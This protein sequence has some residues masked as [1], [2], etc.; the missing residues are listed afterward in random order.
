MKQSDQSYMNV[1]SFYTITPTEFEIRC[2]HILKGYAEKEG[3]P[4]FTITHDEK[5]SAYD[6]SYQ[7][8]ILASFTA[9]GTTIT[10]LCECKRYKSPVKQ[11]VVLALESKLQSIGAHKGIILSTSKFQRGAIEYAQAHGIALIQMTDRGPEYFSHSSGPF[12]ED[13]NDPFLYGERHLPPYRATLVTPN[14]EDDDNVVF[15]PQSLINSIYAEMNR[16]IEEQ[17]GLSIKDRL[18]IGE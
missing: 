8:D 17:Y 14:T 13:P 9:I 4:N 3:L 11:E 1:N 12:E 5:V 15:P 2:T 18:S 10:M 7:I 6:T 16:L